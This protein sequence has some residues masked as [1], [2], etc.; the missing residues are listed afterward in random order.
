MLVSVFCFKII[1]ILSELTIGVKLGE[2]VDLLSRAGISRKGLDI[3]G[4]FKHTTV[5]EPTHIA[6]G[7]KRQFGDGDDYTKKVV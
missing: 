4:R 5:Y 3:Y 1:K 6:R 2:R 7:R